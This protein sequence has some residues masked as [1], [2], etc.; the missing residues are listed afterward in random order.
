MSP[1]SF[2]SRKLILAKANYYMGN[3]EVG[4]LKKHWRSRDIVLRVNHGEE[5]MCPAHQSPTSQMAIY[6]A[7]CARW[8]LI[9]QWVYAS[10][11]LGHKGIKQTTWLVQNAI[12]FLSPAIDK[13]RWGL[14]YVCPVKDT[15][16]V[17]AEREFCDGLTQRLRIHHHPNGCRRFF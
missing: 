6:Q 4:P 2:Y 12:C 14:C 15:P 1:C 13:I 7:I 9:I 16:S 11:S 5:P 10:P 3:R 17:P 8:S